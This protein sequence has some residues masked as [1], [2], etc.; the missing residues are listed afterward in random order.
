MKKISINW[1]GLRFAIRES[2]WAIVDALI[3]V[4]FSIRERFRSRKSIARQEQI[5]LDEY[6]RMLS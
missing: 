3:Q 6:E 2:A 4:A 5:E 1:A